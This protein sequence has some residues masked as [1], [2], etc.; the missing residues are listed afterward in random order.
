MHNESFEVVHFVLRNF[1]SK[2]TFLNL[3]KRLIFSPTFVFETSWLMKKSEVILAKLFLTTKTKREN[4]GLVSD[5]PLAVLWLFIAPF[6]VNFSIFV[7]CLWRLIPSKTSVESTVWI[8][9]LLCNW[10]YFTLTFFS[11]PFLQ[12]IQFLESWSFLPRWKTHIF[13]NRIKKEFFQ[14]RLKKFL[15]ITKIQVVLRCFE[16]RGWKSRSLS[17]C[18]FW[19]CRF[20]KNDDTT[21]L[22]FLSIHVEGLAVQYKLASML[23]LE[24]ILDWVLSTLNA[25]DFIKANL[26]ETL[27]SKARRLVFSKFVVTWCKTARLVHNCDSDES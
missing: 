1:M 24:D 14:A 25:T 2:S 13:Y 5:K 10:V 6:F 18:S 26:V 12:Q 4:C 19:I 15:L 21:C 7:S 17:R 11:T 20:V 27:R 23:M 16:K 3:L 9:S 8:G 22:L